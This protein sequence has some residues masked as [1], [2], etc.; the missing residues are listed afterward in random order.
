MCFPVMDHLIARA[1]NREYIDMTRYDF[2]KK[3]FPPWSD[4]P[5]N[6]TI[7]IMFIGPLLKLLHSVQFYLKLRCPISRTTLEWTTHSTKKA[8]T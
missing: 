1:Y 5:Q 2:S 8:G 6:P 3:K 4:P 7:H